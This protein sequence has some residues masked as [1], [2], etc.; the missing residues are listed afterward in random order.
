MKPR[1]LISLIEKAIATPAKKIIFIWGT[2]QTGKSTILNYLKD[3]YHGSYF[4]FD[5]HEDQRLFIPELSK[6]ESSIIF[7]NHGRPSR[8]IF[9]DEVQTYPESTQSLK[10]L[11]DNT[12]HV[13]IATGSSEMRA[14]TNEF[15][16][17]AGRY[18]EFVLFPLT[19]DEFAIF[20]GEKITF[21]STPTHAEAEL[22]SHYLEEMMIYGSYPAVT[23]SIDKIEELK[24]IT[25][26]SIIKDIVNIYN[27]K[28]TDL[29]Y[30][31]LRLLSMQIGNLINVTELAS[32]LGTT[33]ITIDNYLS[34]LS[35][36]RIIY[37]LEPYKVNKR[38]S[39]LERKKVFFIDLG[40]RN[41]L[42]ED[43]RPLHLRSDLGAVFENLIIMGVLRQMEYRKTHNKL[44]YYRELAGAQKE[45]DLIIETPKGIKTGYEIKYRNGQIN[46]LV[47]LDID[48]YH[49]IAHD[50]LA[51][52]LV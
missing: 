23:L 25:Q 3:K 30:N 21:S 36:N 49:L 42:I 47:D 19:L 34:I 33:K 11:A 5:N 37:L 7:R 41:T 27:L 52:F 45:I 39:Y 17:L 14:K 44:Y 24:N 48:Q 31:L 9:I 6:L 46:K 26:N 1:K 38:R 20:N 32:S 16:T 35:K 51:N 13:I 29:V 40:I 2:R 10:L 18:A 15:D 8:F 4:N 12:D 22:Y 50:N 28:N 43:Y